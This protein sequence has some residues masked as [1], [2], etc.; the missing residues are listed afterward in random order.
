MKKRAITSIYIVLA[1]ILAIL[2]KLLPYSIGDYI[3]DIF[4]LGVTIIAGFEICR[5][6]EA[7]K[8]PVNKFMASMYGIVNYI[9]LILCLNNVSFQAIFLI[10]VGVLV[11]YWLISFVYELFKY[12][13][14]DEY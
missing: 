2:S 14:S 11:A 12:N 9:T 5:M 3:F 1:S 7:N 13:E 6:M 4:I 8:R 10:E